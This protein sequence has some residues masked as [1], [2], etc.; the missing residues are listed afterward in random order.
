MSY[1]YR[2]ANEIVASIAGL[3][4]EPNP[5]LN[6]EQVEDILHIIKEDL[7]MD[8]RTE[9]LFNSLSTLKDIQRVLAK[10][11]TAESTSEKRTIEW[12][13]ENGK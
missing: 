11:G 1:N 10:N 12:L 7:I 6:E 8:D 4:A 9:V 13:E 2:R 5:T 3:S